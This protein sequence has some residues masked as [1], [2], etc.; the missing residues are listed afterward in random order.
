MISIIKCAIVAILLFGIR[1]DWQHFTRVRKEEDVDSK[2][3]GSLRGGIFVV[4]GASGG[5]GAA[6]GGDRVNLEGGWPAI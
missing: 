6:F 5:G 4:G 3:T 1:H 2:D